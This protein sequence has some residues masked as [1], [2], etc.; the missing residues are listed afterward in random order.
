MLVRNPS[1]SCLALRKALD[2]THRDRL[3]EPGDSMIGDVAQTKPQ[4][5][6]GGDAPIGMTRRQLQ[7]TFGE[8][9]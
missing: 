7:N 5:A 8:T 6:R 3:D 1:L 2:F 9:A 4:F